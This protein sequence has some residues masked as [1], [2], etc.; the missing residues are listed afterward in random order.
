MA[1]AFTCAVDLRNKKKDVKFICSM[2]GMSIIGRKEIK[3]EREACYYNY[4]SQFSYPPPFRF[5]SSFFLSQGVP[6]SSLYVPLLFLNLSL[7]LIGFAKLL[8]T[9]HFTLTFFESQ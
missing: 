7:L 4:I 2:K 1:E 5:F 6:F 9:L 3:R 8:P